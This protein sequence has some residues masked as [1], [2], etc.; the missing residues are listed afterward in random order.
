M[1][2]LF[3]VLRWVE[4]TADGHVFDLGR[5]HHE[6][7]AFISLRGERVAVGRSQSGEPWHAFPAGIDRVAGQGAGTGREHMAVLEEG[8]M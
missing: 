1:A 8:P 4:I 5:R 7:L 2:V 3:H 6:P